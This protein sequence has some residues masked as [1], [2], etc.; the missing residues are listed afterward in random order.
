MR[1]TILALDLEGTLISNAISQIPRPGLMTFMEFAQS[2]FSKIV[3]FTSV[4][5]PLVAEIAA[6]LVQEGSAPPWFLKLPY[7]EWVGQTK[8]LRFVST[9]LGETLLLDDHQPYVHPGQLL[10]WVEAPLFAAP[11]PQN[12]MGLQIAAQRIKERISLGNTQS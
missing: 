10:F 3:L 6:L 2:T 1:P 7:V 5:Q 9:R 11:Y 12:D 8:D 4:P